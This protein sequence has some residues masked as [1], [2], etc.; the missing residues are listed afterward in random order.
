MV[1]QNLKAGNI[2]IVLFF[3]LKFENITGQELTTL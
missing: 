2:Q 1:S 3:I